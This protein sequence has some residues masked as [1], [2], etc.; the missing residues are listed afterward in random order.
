MKRFNRKPIA[1]LLVV[2]LLLSMS[3][4]A[5]DGNE[6]VLESSETIFIDN[7]FLMRSVCNE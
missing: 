7:N 3:S 2:F 4:I 5:E 6:V 1:T